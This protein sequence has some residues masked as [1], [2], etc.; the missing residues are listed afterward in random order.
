MPAVARPDSQGC[1]AHT[2]GIP[3]QAIRR[4]KPRIP[5]AARLG[6]QA[7]T[8]E[9]SRA[10]VQ[11]CCHRP[12][13]GRWQH[14]CWEAVARGA[15]KRLNPRC[16]RTAQIMHAMRITRVNESDGPPGVS[17][18]K[19]QQPTAR[20]A[21][22]SCS[23]SWEPFWTGTG[24]AEPTIHER[25]P[26]LTGNYLA[27]AFAVLAHP[28]LPLNFS[29]Y[30]LCQL[31]LVLGNIGH[32]QLRRVL[33]REFKNHQYAHSSTPQGPCLPTVQCTMTCSAH[34]FTR[35]RGKASQSSVLEAGALLREGFAPKQERGENTKSKTQN[36]WPRQ[37]PGQGEAAMPIAILHAHQTH[38]A[39]RTV[40]CSMRQ[41]PDLL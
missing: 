22:K 15:S 10:P 39:L 5:C 12:G 25:T 19:T 1:L 33:L 28:V 32:D 34:P 24:N 4:W 38:Q 41:G 35:S 27:A 40:P 9:S 16:P 17:A 18:W 8:A 31:P 30:L 29:R 11:H 13:Q 2:K 21:A 6:P 26:F 20:L 14:C 7:A 3:G 36:P 23:N 37:A